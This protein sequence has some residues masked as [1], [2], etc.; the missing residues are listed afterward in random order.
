M[1][2]WLWLGFGLLVIFGPRPVLAGDRLE[3]VRGEFD[4][5]S[6]SGS[7]SDDDDD[8]DDDVGTVRALLELSEDEPGKLQRFL[9]YPYANGRRGYIVRPADAK[10]AD[11]V[12]KELAAEV[13]AEGG[14]L[15]DD[16]WRSSLSVRASQSRLYMRGA[17]DLWVEGPRARLDGDLEI[18]GSVH[19]RL[20]RVSFEVGGQF[21]PSEVVTLRFAPVLSVLFEDRRSGSA[22]P[23]VI[24]WLGWSAGMDLFVAR[25][26]VLRA[27]AAIHGSFGVL[28]PHLRATAGINLRR[29]E[30]YAGYDQRWVGAVSL[31][32]PTAGL[33]VR[34]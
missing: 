5:S 1:A 22:S 31:G 4:G 30:L 29:V 7:R 3:R 15:Y 13:Q 20:H 28:M 26:L 11:A 10:Q 21:A 12:G 27:N 8:D 23:L 19:D 33:T 18:R 32:G 16:L 17:Y 2:R 6:S 25:P 14:Y 9:P 34:F 24:P